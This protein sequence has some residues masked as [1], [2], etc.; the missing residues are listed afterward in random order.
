MARQKNDGKGRLGGRAKGTPNKSTATFRQ[1][2]TEL[3]DKNRKQIE[4]DLKSL[5]PE[6]RLR[7]V[8]KLMAYI[9]PKQQA[10]S[11]PPNL[12]NISEDQLENVISRITAAL[13]E[14]EAQ[15]SQSDHS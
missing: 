6:A 11:T 3:L 12:D 4:K 13:T 8:E 2:L 10:I 15:E 7:M 1:W 9:M 14:S 5:D